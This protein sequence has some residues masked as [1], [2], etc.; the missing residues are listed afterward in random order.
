VPGQGDYAMRSL[1][2]R[3][4]VAHANNPIITMTKAMLTSANEILVLFEFIPNF[5][6]VEHRKTSRM[7]PFLRDIS[8][9]LPSK[10]SKTTA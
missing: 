2:Y 3:Y 8:L 1:R 9:A 4:A 7:L 5:G 6:I 10:M